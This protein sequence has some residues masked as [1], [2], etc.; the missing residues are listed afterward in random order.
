[1]MAKF[2][3][4]CGQP[5]FFFTTAAEMLITLPYRVPFPIRTTSYD[6]F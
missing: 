6:K 1:M 4:V 5:S 3:S 2:D